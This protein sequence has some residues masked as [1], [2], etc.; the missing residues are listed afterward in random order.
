MRLYGR[1]LDNDSASLFFKY[2]IVGEDGNESK[3]KEIGLLLDLSKQADSFYDLTIT[4]KGDGTKALYDDGSYKTTVTSEDIINIKK[5]AQAAYNALSV[6]DNRTL[7]I[8]VN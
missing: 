8:I 6:K 4:N 3:R 2:S 1:L 5:L 7:Y